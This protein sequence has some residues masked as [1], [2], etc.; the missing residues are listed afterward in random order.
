VGQRQEIGA[1]DKGFKEKMESF[2]ED[3]LPPYASFW[4]SSSAL[5]AV[6]AILRWSE[7]GD[8]RAG[9]MLWRLQA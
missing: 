3:S 9:G 1:A 2:P 6:S 7:Q 8:E 5:C 4:P